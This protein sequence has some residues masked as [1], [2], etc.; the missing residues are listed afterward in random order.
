[1]KKILLSLLLIP[2]AGFS[3]NLIIQNFDVFP[4]SWTQTNQSTTAGT[5]EGSTWTQGNA[6][7]NTYIN[8][9]AGGFNGGLTS[10]SW[11]NFNSTTGNST[12]SNWLITPVVSLMNGDV[13][14]FYIIK[15]L[16]GG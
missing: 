1:M 4:T 12:I 2:I 9:G 15:G 16:S 3:Q 5:T 13:I 7:S 14:S 8:G 11:V 10:Y 6:T